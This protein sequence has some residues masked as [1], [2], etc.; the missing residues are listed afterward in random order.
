MEH[1]RHARPDCASGYWRAPRF[2]AALAALAVLGSLESPAGAQSQP[3][4]V[5]SASQPARDTTQPATDSTPPASA[6]TKPAALRGLRDGGIETL[7]RSPTE[8]IAWQLI[9]SALIVLLLG[10]ACYV[11]MR[12]VMPRIQRHVGRNIQIL[13]TAHLGPQK[14][15]H[16]LKVGQDTYLIASTKDRVSLLA[17]IPTKPV[18]DGPPIADGL[19]LGVP[20]RPR[21]G[22]PGT[23]MGDDKP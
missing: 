14:M 20:E 4:Q 16:L 8:N 3:A 22:P 11:I 2:L 18:R 23:A 6:S 5:E 15:V 13:E 12:K 7:K 21:A 17:E 19:S 9:S 1:C 10:I